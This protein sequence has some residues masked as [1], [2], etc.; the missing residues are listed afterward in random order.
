MST[1]NG[2]HLAAA[3]LC[4]L[5]SAPAGPA[6]AQDAKLAGAAAMARLVGNT[7]TGA[8]PD[9]PYAELFGADGALT[10][11]DRDGKAGGRWILKGDRVCLDVD[12][13]EDCRSIEVQG[14]SGAFTDDGGARYPFAIIPGNPQGL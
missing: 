12:D 8:T 6:L 14:Q 4:C 5:T 3:L 7:V 10:I 9:G 2:H 11:V 13:D 1:F